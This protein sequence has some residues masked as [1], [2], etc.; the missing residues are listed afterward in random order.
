MLPRFIHNQCCD[1]V[2]DGEQLYLD[3]FAAVGD[4]V[5]IQCHGSNSTPILWQYKNPEEINDLDQDLY[6]GQKL[7]GDCVNKCTIN[8]STYDLTILEV[9]VADAGE[10]WCVEDEGFGLKHVTKLFITGNI[11]LLLLG[12]VARAIQYVLQTHADIGA[13]LEK[14]CYSVDSIHLTN[15]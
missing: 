1:S 6:D 13:S 14:L 15:E 8:S 7:V 12:C 10:Y 5:T 11:S 2:V 4:N 9:A 3:K